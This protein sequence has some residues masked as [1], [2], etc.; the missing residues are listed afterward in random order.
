MRNLLPP[1]LLL[2]LLT[3]SAAE[4]REREPVQ[5]P[6][7]LSE[8][9]RNQAHK[10]YVGGR[11]A[12]VLRFEKPCDPERTRML[13]WEGH[14]EP[15]LVGGRSVLLYPLR[16]LTPE[17][18]FLLQVMLTDGTEVPFIVTAREQSVTEPLHGVDQQVDVFADREGYDSVLAALYRSLRK[19]R[20]LREQNERLLQEEN[21]VD[22]AY[23]TL[24]ANG[25]VEGAPFR[26]K[27]RVV[28]KNEDM[29]MEVLLFAGKGKAAAVVRLSNTYSNEPW[30]LRDARLTAG[31]TAGTSRPFA[32]RM[33]RP[34]IVPG[35]SGTLAVVV[36]KSAFVSEEGLV[37]LT[38][39]IFRHDGLQQAVVL[40]EHRLLRE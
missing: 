10:V 33:S 29:G 15:L 3:A 1:S 5:R 40:L 9:P 13:G 19:E 14:F 34:E 8:H 35:A 25:G 4:A 37:D 20:E 26:L 16:D 32:L 31:L 11:I 6:L 39:E 7:I 28:L 12:T 21:S 17:D 30:R 23:A 38:L 27:R 36:D 24:L 18:R 2:L 22:H